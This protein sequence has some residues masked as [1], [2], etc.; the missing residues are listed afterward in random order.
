MNVSSINNI[1]RG[2]AAFGKNKT[3]EK[4]EHGNDKLLVEEHTKHPIKTG[5]KIQADKFSKAFTTYPKKGLEGSKNA[6]F[7]EFLTMGMVPYLTG[8][9]AMIGVFNLASKF[10][11]TPSAVSAT[12][13]LGKQ[14]GLGVVLYGIGKT[15]SKKLI[16]TPVK[17]KYGVDV[18]LPYKK[19]INE[20]PEER[21]KN[22][23]VSYEYHKAYESVDFPRWDLFYDNEHYGPERNSYY[24]MIAKKFGMED[25]KYSDQQVKDK[26]REKV[27]QTKVFSSITSFLWAATGVAIAAQ[28]PW[29]NLIINPKTR[30]KNFTKHVKQVK[31]STKGAQKGVLESVKQIG[32]YDFFAKDFVKKF[33]QSCKELLYIDSSALKR[34]KT[35]LSS[36]E[37]IKTVEQNLITKKP[38]EKFIK[39]CKKLSDKGP[40]VAKIAGRT[41]VGLAVGVTLLGNFKTL[42]DFNN[43]RGNKSQGAS[44]IFDE[45]KEKVVC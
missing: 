1:N 45:N 12:K 10:F 37:Q 3:E 36:P 38:S 20:L 31:N 17:W 21:N 34:I 16:E 4:K 18:N 8:S 35:K 7:Y 22:N 13:G 28:K 23:L 25:V 11:D 41:L 30:V 26:I 44:P 5:L 6:N 2:H 33:A 19:K 32:K 14:M 9:A 24:D 43:N 40:N 27:V 39:E 15:L 29:Q 42:F